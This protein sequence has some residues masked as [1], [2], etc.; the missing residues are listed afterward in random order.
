MQQRSL[1]RLADTF[2]CIYADVRRSRSRI[3]SAGFCFSS[4]CL[5]QSLPFCSNEER[6]ITKDLGVHVCLLERDY[7]LYS[8]NGHAR[9]TLVSYVSLSPSI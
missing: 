2:P 7:F 1:Y 4:Q 5:P 3:V 8:L 9:S 6:Y